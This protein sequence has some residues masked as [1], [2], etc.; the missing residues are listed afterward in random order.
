MR[1]QLLNERLGRSRLRCLLFCP[2]AL[3]CE[4]M[5]TGRAVEWE[6][7]SNASIN[8][9]THHHLI[10]PLRR[11]GRKEDG[12]DTVA[13]ILVDNHDH[14][15]CARD[16]F[17]HPGWSSACGSKTRTAFEDSRARGAPLVKQ[18][19]TTPPSKAHQQNVPPSYVL[20]AGP[21]LEAKSYFRVWHQRL[22]V[23]QGRE[24]GAL[25]GVAMFFQTKRL[26]LM[27]VWPCGTRVRPA[28]SEKSQVN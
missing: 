2:M 12:C 22:P 27:G 23:G 4:R 7:Y 9:R 21:P 20:G 15:V 6:R 19:K 16:F 28:W 26:F 3:H 17:S 24:K 1:D 13:R 5:N 25:P 10:D 14:T 18:T 11:E 8:V